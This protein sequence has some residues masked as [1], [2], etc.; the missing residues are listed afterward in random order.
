MD[1][2]PNRGSVVGSGRGIGQ[3]I[4]PSEAAERE[5]QPPQRRRTR[6]IVRRSLKSSLG[7]RIRALL[8]GASLAAASACAAPQAA[9]PS[10]SGQPAGLQRLTTIK[11]AD[12]HSLTFSPTDSD[13]LFFG[14]HNG[15]MRSTDG[16][17]SWSAVV[18]RPNFDAMNL[19]TNPAAPQ[20]LWMAGHN[21]FFKSTDSGSSWEPVTTNLPG[22]DLHAFATS[23][24]D[25][26]TL[27]AFAVGFG[28]FKS[29]NAG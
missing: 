27:Y 1:R 12:Y 22:L 13:I 10:A 15:I 8:I 4:G 28:L 26:N 23:S 25:P 21:V 20:V 11:A 7:W 17:R 16:G 6:M 3:H 9:R 24:A 19:V 29:S 5:S 2:T 18:D 14:H